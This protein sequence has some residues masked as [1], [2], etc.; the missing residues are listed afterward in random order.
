MLEN[1]ESKT[2]AVNR[3]ILERIGRTDERGLETALPAKRPA[4]SLREEA[5]PWLKDSVS[6]PKDSYSDFSAI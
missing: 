5:G 6:N 2:A 4:G 1:P 3:L